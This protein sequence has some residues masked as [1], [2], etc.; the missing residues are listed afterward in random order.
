MRP[1]LAV[2]ATRLDLSP[3]GI[4]AQL[5]QGRLPETHN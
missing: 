1:T 3:A 2:S 4:V 5:R